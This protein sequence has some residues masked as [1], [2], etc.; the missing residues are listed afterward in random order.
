MVEMSCR[1]VEG[2]NR[3]NRSDMMKNT[4]GCGKN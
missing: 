4:E 2:N 3:N 1:I